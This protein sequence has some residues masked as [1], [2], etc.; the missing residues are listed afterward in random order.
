[1]VSAPFYLRTWQQEP[2]DGDLFWLCGVGRD[3]GTGKTFAGALATATRIQAGFT[4]LLIG[5]NHEQLRT[6]V[7]PHEGLMKFIQV[8]PERMNPREEVIWPGGGR[9]ILRTLDQVLERVP[10]GDFA[11]AWG[12]DL[13]GWDT[14]QAKYEAIRRM[15]R[16]LA[17][18]VQASDH[19]K[20]ILS[21]EMACPIFMGDDHARLPEGFAEQLAASRPGG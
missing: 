4:V 18:D 5:R 3:R 6:M 11:A 13:V 2:S 17:R 14:S 21:G 20:I 7:E 8:R 9:A 15:L 12:D 10:K 19:P 1:M 16:V